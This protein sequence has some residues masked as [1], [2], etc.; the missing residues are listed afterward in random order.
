MK[1]KNI[2]LKTE[3]N[4]WYERNRSSLNKRNYDKDL[5]VNEIIKIN[6][7]IGSKPNHL[8][9]KSKKGRILEV[10]CGDAGFVIFKK[11]DYDCYGIEPSLK[12]RKRSQ[13]RSRYMPWYSR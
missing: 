12:C 10:G 13:P 8:K 4:K 3:G 9:P 1:Q 2:F 7:F 5:I 6:D 11:F